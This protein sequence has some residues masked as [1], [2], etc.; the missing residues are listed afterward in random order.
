MRNGKA[1][2][3]L[4]LFSLASV[5]PSGVSLHAPP[6]LDLGAADA[7]GEIHAHLSGASGIHRAAL[8][9]AASLRGHGLLVHRLRGGLVGG[10][11]TRLAGSD[12]SESDD[13]EQEGK[14]RP[15]C[16][17]CYDE[18]PEGLFTPCKCSGSM[19]YVHKE[20]LRHWRAVNVYERAF[21]HCTMCAAEYKLSDSASSGPPDT[22]TYRVARS[23]ATNEC[24]V[25]ATMLSLA[26]TLVGESFENSGLGEA[27]VRRFPALLWVRFGPSPTPRRPG[28]WIP[29]KAPRADGGLWGWSGGLAGGSGTPATVTPIDGTP[30][31]AWGF[32][33]IEEVCFP[34]T[35]TLLACLPSHAH[36]RAHAHIHSRLTFLV[37]FDGHRASWAG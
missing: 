7:G 1:M 23:L 34:L 3:R 11:V 32:S 29:G 6:A 22:W 33:E 37:T 4:A 30:Q 9:Q 10:H 12:W 17:I 2:G 18:D 15:M 19:R 25:T 35:P 36:V 14:W 16:R 26:V 20:C 27:L 24:A 5:F 8:P 28:P 31:S 13:S 21:T